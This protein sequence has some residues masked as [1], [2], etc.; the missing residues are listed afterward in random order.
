MTRRELGGFS[1]TQN[2]LQVREESLGRQ[3]GKEGAQ[4][5]GMQHTE[6]PPPRGAGQ[7]P[8]LFIWGPVFST[9]HGVT[10]VASHPGHRLHGVE[11]ASLGGCLEEAVSRLHMA[12]FVTFP[13]TLGSSCSSSSSPK[14]LSP[15]FSAFLPFVSF[16]SSIFSLLPSSL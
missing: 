6:S 10:M 4:S 9:L 1:I 7:V 15:S 16:I 2:A 11:G 14:F 8:G 13:S 3:I 12:V 5:P